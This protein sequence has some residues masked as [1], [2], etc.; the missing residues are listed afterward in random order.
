MKFLKKFLSDV[1]PILLI[2]FVVSCSQKPARIDNH[3]RNF[4]SK[5]S[6]SSKVKNRNSSEEK[7]SRNH[8]IKVTA[9]ETLFS[10]SKKHQ[11]TLR[12]LIKQNNL[13]PPYS[14]KVGTKLSIPAPAYHEVKPGET[15]Y[16]ISRAYNMKID[17]LIEMNDL[18][19]PYSLKVGEKIRIANFTDNQLTSSVATPE[20]TEAEQA[21][22]QVAYRLSSAE[23]TVEKN[24]NLLKKL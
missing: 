4:Y 1:V 23:K 11:V 8:Q 12:D 20:K 15:I 7:K 22:S 10:L 6:Q 5:G 24:W 3:S 16:A 9:G 17:N 19:A 21:S 13:V 18:K 2:F 14:L